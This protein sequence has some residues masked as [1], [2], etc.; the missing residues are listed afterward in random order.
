MA[1]GIQKYISGSKKKY[2]DCF[3]VKKKS[4]TIRTFTN[5]SIHSYRPQHNKK[6]PF[7]F[8]SIL[9]WYADNKLY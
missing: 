9:F 1:F 7:Y 6:A 4:I 8:F 3:V 5:F 2:F